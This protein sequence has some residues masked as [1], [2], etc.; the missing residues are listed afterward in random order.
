MKVFSIRN[1]RFTRR[2]AMIAV[3]AA[4]A[5]WVLNGRV[6]ADETPKAKPGSQKS[7]K[8]SSKAWVPEKKPLRG[9]IV[10]IWPG[11]HEGNLQSFLEKSPWKAFCERHGFAFCDGT[12]DVKDF[13]EIGKEL[14]RPELANAP[15]VL[16]GLSSTGGQAILKAHEMPDRVIA[17]LG[18]QPFAV[19]A[20]G[21]DGFNFHRPNRHY[22]H[23]ITQQGIQDGVKGKD[24]F[25]KLLVAR[26]RGGNLASRLDDV[27]DVSRA[28]G[29]PTLIQTGP[30]DNVLGSAVAYGLFDFGR[31]HNAPWT[32]F[33]LPKRGHGGP[34]SFDVAAPW[35]EAVIA[36]RLPADMD[37]SKGP[38]KLKPI[39]VEAGWLGNSQTLS[40]AEHSKY[41]GNKA[42]ASWFPDHTSAE[43]WKKHGLGMPYEIPEQSV[44][45]PSGLIEKLVIHDP[46]NDLVIPP[47][48]MS[49]DAWKIVADLK[50]GDNYCMGAGAN[51]YRPTCVGKVPAL[52]RGSDWIRPDNISA[53]FKG[54]TLME[55]TVRDAAIVYVAHDEK[56]ANKP[57]WLA[58]WKDTGE[59]V[60]VGFL[61]NER[62]LRLFEK[63]FAKNV[64][65]KLGRNRDLKEDAKASQNSDPWIYMTIVK[66]QATIRQSDEKPRRPS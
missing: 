31:K 22:E 1:I 43:A 65:V 3:L 53:D 15:V 56:I 47:D 63:A 25:A 38:P 58:D 17:A 4:F 54:E 66:P 48:A 24:A 34:V 7:Q 55:F 46:K 33:C 23:F 50:E 36:Q 11:V 20:K 29:V 13:A 49:G 62:R 19:L 57:A 6:A 18:A 2:L 12:Q 14:G 5:Y 59:V 32:Y 41:D 52:V 44:K 27:Y 64:T 28:F 37:L 30:D 42:K 9:I 8:W 39:R 21:N 26:G 35:L 60:Q 61:G 45:L 16:T 40:I 51:W 10:Q